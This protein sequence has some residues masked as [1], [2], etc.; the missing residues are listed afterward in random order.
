VGRTPSDHG[1][2]DVAEAERRIAWLRHEIDYHNYRYYV[3][4]DPEVSDA[5]YD[6]F[7]RELL[8]L[9]TRYPELKSPNSPT[10]RVGAAPLDAFGTVTHALPM[11]SLANAMEEGE[12]QDFDE[13]IRRLLKIGRD[14]EYVAE[15]KLDGLAVELVYAHGEFSVGSTRGDGI[16]GEDVTQNLRTLK[17][18]PL[19]LVQRASPVPERLDVRGEV[20]MELHDFQELNR[21]RQETG[22]PLFANPRNAAAGSLRQLNP[23]VTAQRPLKIFCY[24]TGVVHGWSFQRQWDV[25]E[26]FRTWGLRVNPLVRRCPSIDAVVAYYHELTELRGE[27]PYEVD[28]IVVKVDKIS[29]QRML[30]EVSRSPRWAIAYKFPPKQATTRILDIVVQVGRTGALTPVA[31]MEPVRLAGVEIK[32]ATLHNQDEID[33]KDIRIGDV[34]VIQRAGDVIPEVVTP[35]ISVRTGQER[36]FTIPSVCPVCGGEVIRI[37]GEAIH[38]CIN[39]SCPAQ[40]KGHILHFASKRA[41]DIDGLGAK[42]VDQLVDNG[43]VTTVADLYFLRTDQLANL[44]RMANKSADNLF[45]AIEASKR[46]TL[47]RLLYALGIRHVGEHIAQLLATHLGSIEHVYT[48]QQEELL[49]IPEIGPKVA[50]SVRSFF[51]DDRNRDVIERLFE[52]GVSVGDESVAPEQRPLRKK[53]FLFTGAMDRLSRDDAKNLVQ[54]LG[55]EV[56]SSP[57]RRVDYVVVG[58][59]PGSKLASARELGL[60]IIDEQEFLRLIRSVQS[61]KISQDD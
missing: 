39:M 50:H 19:H 38:R 7:M 5:Q 1:S 28:G 44:E 20:Y 13:R 26:S 57:S 15:P 30:G 12:I 45:H 36:Y 4:D 32:S 25:L 51:S 16:T 23:A 40:I 29:L 53:R 9:E 35:V 47:S 56:A 37:H 55:G 46:T 22:E 14:I 33:K 18:I 42:L 17:T 43:L 54:S 41:M 49:D 11:L 24:G 31:K 59:N 2:T 27:L 52:A 48:A 34:V 58:D 60:I 21:T 61:S 10:Q 8:D 6:E 3:L